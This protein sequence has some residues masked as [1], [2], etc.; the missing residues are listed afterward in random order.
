MTPSDDDVTEVVIEEATSDGGRCDSVAEDGRSMVKPRLIVKVE[1]GWTDTGDGDVSSKRLSVS[2]EGRMAKGW[3]GRNVN[4]VENCDAWV[5]DTRSATTDE[6]RLV[7]DDDD[8]RTMGAVDSSNEMGGGLVDGH[9]E[10][11]M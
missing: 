7:E 5:E 3:S 1:D 9:G 11:A 10:I 4:F 6:V 2:V 8:E